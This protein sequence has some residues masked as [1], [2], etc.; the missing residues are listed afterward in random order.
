VGGSTPIHHHKAEISVRKRQ[1]YAGQHPGQ[2]GRDERL[3][4]TAAAR[5]E[6]VAK[7]GRV[8]H[9]EFVGIKTKNSETVGIKLVA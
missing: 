9:S 6:E 3:A 7:T 1:G 8:G 5:L 2:N 4:K